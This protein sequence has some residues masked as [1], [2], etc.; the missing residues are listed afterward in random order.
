MSRRRDTTTPSQLE[1]GSAVSPSPARDAL[2]GNLE[3]GLTLNRKKSWFGSARDILSKALKGDG[4]SKVDET[5]D[6]TISIQTEES[7]V[8]QHDDSSTTPLRPRPER[9][10]TFT[11]RNAISSLRQHIS[12]SNHRHKRPALANI[13]GNEIRT[14]TPIGPDS[15]VISPAPEDEEE[16][17]AL[18]THAR[19]NSLGKSLVGS[20][21]TFGRK[22]MSGNASPT[23]SIKEDQFSPTK[24]AAA[25]PL[26]SSPID[27]PPPPTLHVDL[28]P[29][30][31][32]PTSPQQDDESELMR[33]T[34]PANLIGERP[35]P[36]YY[37]RLPGEGPSDQQHL[38]GKKQ[39]LT[40][41]DLLQLPTDDFGFSVPEGP[42]T[43]SR[44]SGF[45]LDGANDE[46]ELFER[47]VEYK[48][49]AY[50]KENRS[51]KKMVS[52]D[53][54]AEECASSPT[55]KSPSKLLMG[56]PRRSRDHMSL[57][58]IQSFPEDMPEITRQLAHLQTPS[59]GHRDPTSG[60]WKSGDPFAPSNTI[61][62][63]ASSGP[64]SPTRSVKL[65]LRP[66][67]TVQSAGS[68]D[69]KTFDESDLQTPECVKDDGVECKEE[70][71]RDSLIFDGVTIQNNQVNFATKDAA[72]TTFKASN[73]AVIG[74]GAKSRESLAS[75][76]D[77]GEYGE[78]KTQQLFGD[79]SAPE[80]PE[81]VDA[82]GS[83]RASLET[84]PQRRRSVAQLYHRISNS[85]TPSPPR[86]RP[87]TTHQADVS[88]IFWK[89]DFKDWPRLS[90]DA[91]EDTPHE[92]IGSS[93]ESV[94]GSDDIPTNASP[95]RTPSMG[96]RLE[97]GIKR[98]AR[99]M[100]YNALRDMEDTPEH[101]D[102]AKLPEFLQPAPHRPTL[103]IDTSS[104]FKTRNSSDLSLANFDEAYSSSRQVSPLKP[105]TRQSRV[106]MS[107]D[108]IDHELKHAISQHYVFQA[109]VAG[110]GITEPYS[111][112]TATATPSE[113]HP[114]FSNESKT[115]PNDH[116][117]ISPSSSAIWQDIQQGPFDTPPGP[118]N[119]SDQEGELHAY[120][121]KTPFADSSASADDDTLDDCL[122]MFHNFNKS[123]EMLSSD[124]VQPAEK[125]E[126][127]F[128]SSSSSSSPGGEGRGSS[129]T[130]SPRKPLPARYRNSLRG[131][132]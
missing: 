4:S 102:S 35:V 23:K 129:T 113:N 31:L 81:Y 104:D 79:L 12:S 58:T 117:P 43:P 94:A 6:R 33:I 92:S 20:I 75:T 118:S 56:D 3:S 34:N 68:T 44:K 25:V 131:R 99:N 27:I 90:K 80:L 60:E 87:G 21:R 1:R 45:Q 38:L 71:R 76:V 17:D 123:Q 109:A 2:Q 97:F 57:T 15:I 93:N 50:K 107:S 36:T 106:G 62:D 22:S 54:M 119:K 115:T 63:L 13:T 114:M 65:P 53:A 95:N 10:R 19:K 74:D 47:S 29:A 72:A 59:A 48:D 32:M 39:S 51:L 26:P 46:I 5:E 108:S 8:G 78:F 100:R 9:Q 125:I 14:S 52:L 132:R 127:P 37:T 28:G 120:E 111:S 18:E 69:P 103:K 73:E 61:G 96:D 24:H 82:D 64:P 121:F 85:K 41:S 98:S 126:N 11:P 30:A 7:E 101:E 88:D 86:C 89:Y 116:H 70:V 91:G 105:S 124:S 122:E 66:K 83:G 40:P 16:Q 112:S 55:A 130:T 110:L 49:K 42:T 128:A 67:I 77:S 84:S